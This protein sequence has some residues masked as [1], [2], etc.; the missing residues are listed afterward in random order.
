MMF[1]QPWIFA[2]WFNRMMFVTEQ[3]LLVFRVVWR[4]VPAHV[5]TRRTKWFA[6]LLIPYRGPWFATLNCSR[7]LSGG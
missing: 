3:L 2:A 1:S 6:C 7:S 4:M 5:A